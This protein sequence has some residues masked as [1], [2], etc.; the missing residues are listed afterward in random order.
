MPANKTTLRLAPFERYMLVD[1]RP[2]HPMHI[3]TRLRFEGPLDT[4][5]L[6]E[7]TQATLAGHPLLTATLSPAHRWQFDGTRVAIQW[8]D[9]AFA[10]TDLNL[11]PIDLR[12]EPGL[13]IYA[14]TQGLQSEV[15]IQVHHACCDGLGL[16]GFVEDLLSHYGRV[17]GE[18]WPLPQRN[19][20]LLSQ[21][22]QLGLTGKDWWKALSRQGRAIC[23]TLQFL[24]RPAQTLGTHP[25]QSH[26][27]ERTFVFD[28]LRLALKASQQLLQRARDM[29][30]TLN[31]LL[32]STLLLTLH[33][34]K[35]SESDSPWLR[36][37][38]P[39]N[40]R[41]AQHHLL[42]ATNWVSLMFLTRRNRDLQSPS[43]LIRSIHQEMSR[44]KRNQEGMTFNLG[45]ALYHRLGL[46]R[47]HCEVSHCRTTA[48]MS[49]LGVPLSN[50][51]GVQADG[52]V[53]L[54]DLTLTEMDFLPPIRP[55]THLSLGVF[56]YAQ[57][58]CLSFHVDD[59]V[60]TPQQVQ[61]LQGDFVRRLQEWN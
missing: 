43:D 9:T 42:P 21:R 13:K 8:R 39:M 23:S 55:L 47:P 12:Q 45:L 22:H 40:Y 5:Q 57:Q 16:L 52:R 33:D 51:P 4:Q 24:R 18:S 61:K 54:G 14:H 41:Q 32:L 49:N 27:K 44:I 11:N 25:S 30:V 10:P 53:H 20:Q 36:L 56:T 34:Q 6:E 58:L 15:V 1:D 50:H 3:V 2:S 35:V 31:D 7:A 60:L 19:Q 46:L 29:Q 38:V 26:Q 59:T 37:C 17:G 48:V 28:T